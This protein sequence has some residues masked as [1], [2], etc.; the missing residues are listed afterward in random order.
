MNSDILLM[1]EPFGAVDAK[2]RAILQD[3]LL[4]I[5]E[6]GQHRKTVIFVTHDIDEAIL[7]SDRII[8]MTAGPGTVKKEIDVPFKR[9]RERSL[10]VKTKEYANLRNQIVDLFYDD[11][12]QKIG[13][14]EVLL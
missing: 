12:V 11:L 13:G 1:D 6:G 3:L 5:W 10:L 9:P 4:K 7:L 14:E 8:V 2:N